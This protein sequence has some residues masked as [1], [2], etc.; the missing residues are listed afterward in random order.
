MGVFTV[1]WLDKPFN[2]TCLIRFYFFFCAGFIEEATFTLSN[3]GQFKLIHDGY[4][5]NKVNFSN[6][7]G[8]TT[9]RC[10]LNQTYRDLKCYAKAYTK[11]VG[12][13]QKVKKLG[14]HTHPAN[15]QKKKPIRKN[16]KDKR[17]K[18]KKNSNNWY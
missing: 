10:S 4:G 5:Y 17:R 7:S 15:R 18:L 3:R 13:I 8:I 11:Q 2:C 14:E 6:A 9:W 12:S 16:M 1:F